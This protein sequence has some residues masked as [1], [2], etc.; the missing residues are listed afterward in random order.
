MYNPVNI[1]HLKFFFDAALLKSVSE[2]AKKNFVTQ[3]AISQAIIKLERDLGAELATHSRQSFHVTEEGMIVVEQARHIFQAIQDMQDKINEGKGQITGTVNFACTNSLGMSFVD[4]AFKDMQESYPQVTLKMQL[5]NLHYIRSALKERHA[6]LAIVVYEKSFEPFQKCSLL[7]GQFRLYQN[8][9]M[10]PSSIEKGILVDNEEG[11]HVSSLQ[12]SYQ[13]LYKEELA[14]QIELGGWEVVA[15][16]TE[17][18]VGVGFFP[19]YILL[20][21]RYPKIKPWVQQK[22]KFELPSIDYEICAIYPKG[23]KLSRAA[24]AFIDKLKG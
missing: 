24:T 17:Q 5:G 4:K 10:A 18:G 11:M 1:Q 19:D 6:E 12:K 8:N 9:K 20:N 22:S 2:A 3:S 15:R 7:Q 16:F 13:T 21:N 14:V 23:Q